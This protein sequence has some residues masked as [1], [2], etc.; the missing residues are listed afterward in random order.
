VTRNCAGKALSAVSGVPKTIS[1]W[2]KMQVTGESWFNLD[3]FSFL[4]R[5][6]SRGHK[7]CQW[8]ERK[9]VIQ[10]TSHAMPSLLF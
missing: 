10:I 5:D 9:N 1:L 8:I 4:F 6:L 3:E 7:A 2:L